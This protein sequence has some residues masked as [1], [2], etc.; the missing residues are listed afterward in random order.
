M[1]Q[2]AIEKPVHAEIPNVQFQLSS[3]FP[4]CCSSDMPG[5]RFALPG[6]Q[7]VGSSLNS[8]RRPTLIPCLASNTLRA[9]TAA[10]YRSAFRQPQPVSASQ[11]QS[12]LP[13]SPPISTSVSVHHPSSIWGNSA[14]MAASLP[15]VPI[16]ASTEVSTNPIISTLSDIL[17]AS[18]LPSYG[19][20]IVLATFF[21]RSALTLPVT[22]WQRRRAT[23]AMKQIAP[24]L[25]AYNS[26]VAQE[27]VPI[28]RKKGFSAAQY[29]AEVVKKVR[30]YLLSIG[31]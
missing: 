26:L 8:V 13:Q 4:N 27:L 9:G 31:V 19:I 11:H 24:E 5:R 30:W 10:G 29:Q 28:A 22:L 17:L 18:P 20:T 12:F 16:V 25:K 23:T 7:L 15:I 1:T 14:F 3:S 21:L 6:L 2:C